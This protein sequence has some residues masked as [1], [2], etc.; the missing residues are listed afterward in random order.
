[1]KI[2]IQLS[3]QSKPTLLLVEL[4]RATLM[5]VI[6]FVSLTSWLALAVADVTLPTLPTST[7]A[8]WFMIQ[9]ICGTSYFFAKRSVRLAALYLIL[10]LWSC[11]LVTVY[12]L[13]PTFRNLLSV[14]SIFAGFLLGR[15]LAITIT[16][17]SSLFIVAQHYPQVSPDDL[18]VL[19]VMWCILFASFVA[20]S[21]L[22]QA[23]DTAWRYENYAIDQMKEAREH[24]AELMRLT[25]ALMDA[26]SDLE[27][28]NRQLRYARHVAEEARILKARFAANVSHELRTPINLIVGFAEM[29]VLGSR[30]YNAPLPSAYSADINAIFRNAKHLQGLI[31]DVLDVSQI[32]AGQLAVGKEEIDPR[33]VVLDTGELMRDMITSRNLEFKVVVPDRL[34]PMRLDRIRIRQVILNLLSNA[35]RFTDTGTITL[36]AQLDASHLYIS[37]TDTGIGIR[38][39]D[40]DRVFEEFQQ[41]DNSL[42]RR[43][44]G[45]GLGLT[46]S[47]QFVEL[48][49]GQ[50]SVESGGVGQGTTFTATLPLDISRVTPLI[51]S[52]RTRSVVETDH[53]R[54]FVIYDR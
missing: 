9:V 29:I 52:Y 5:R 53:S 48:H 35:V 51:G 44:G 47:K 46:L 10:G 45:S 13:D 4:R 26:K 1:M 31:N 40:L 37:V 14:V 38:Q 41:L 8:I 54:V 50:L 20:V 2:M 39:E 22:Y 3:P 15:R 16:V 27:N 12:Y 36:A 43:H 34:P 19:T 11:N 21:S 49:G 30:A 7:L 17:L 25:I 32:E 6:W 42:S 33:L 28:V 23:L 18:L 24:R